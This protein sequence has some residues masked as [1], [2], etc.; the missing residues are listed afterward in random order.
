LQQEKIS[1]K[2]AAK[3]LSINYSTAKTIVQT[4]RREKRIAKKP[5][6][7]VE[8]KQAKKRERALCR[9]LSANKVNTIVEMILENEAGIGL[10]TKK[11]NEPKEEIKDASTLPT[12]Q[13]KE[14]ENPLKHQN[15]FGSSPDF[16]IFQE[17]EDG[18]KEDQISRGVGTHNDLILLQPK[19][20]IFYTYSNKN[21]EDEYKEKIDYSNLVI[22]RSKEAEFNEEIELLPSSNVF[23]E[24]GEKKPRS[25]TS[26]TE[27]EK[28]FFNFKFLAEDIY[29]SAFER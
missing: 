9:K 18:P 27:D 22:F 23:P 25:M 14:P 1:L 13:P 21:M 19:K 16:T 7:Q 8:T 12:N 29:F 28:P 17:K 24:V 15:N 20:P 11:C 6:R 5:K 10:T 3:E 2:E 26:I 4:F